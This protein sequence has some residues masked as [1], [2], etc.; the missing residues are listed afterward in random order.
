MP[1]AT[2][3]DDRLERLR[4]ILHECGSACV[5]YSGGVDS[6]FLASFAVETL[7]PERVLA[8]T[9]L[10]P[11]YPAV[12]REVARECAARFGIPHLEVETAE[13]DDPNYAANPANRC[14]Y[15][16]SE[17]WPRLAAVA[18]ERGYAAVLDGSN[19]DDAGD[20]RP[21]FVAARE[22]GVR[23]PLLEAGLTKDDIR[24]LSRERG[25][26][27]WDQPAAPCLSSR[28]PYG[29][30]VTPARLRQVELAEAALRDLGYR[31]F[32][33]RHHDDCLRL[34]F[35]PAE[36]EQAARSAAAIAAALHALRTPAPLLDVEGYRRGALNEVLV[37]LGAAASQAATPHGA[38]PQAATPHGATPQAATSHG[39]TPQAATPHAGGDPAASSDQPLP[40]HRAAGFHR[41][42][43]VPSGQ[44]PGQDAAQLL[45]VARGLVPRLRAAGFRYVA[46]DLQDL[47]GRPR[48]GE[49]GAGG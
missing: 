35:A 8:V 21:G 15:C 23:S 18:V 13:L 37:Q 5:G 29:V 3:L 6:V 22:N 1:A 38:T 12:Q 19:A 17:L 44:R 20:Y 46:L 36:L 31:E 26:P 4:Q 2:T 48:P 24:A 34:E 30:A 47:A 14:Y 32:R 9:G 10:S 25:L 7:G 16:K 27:T 33:V 40:P 49:R 41:D 43:A 39:A 42:I 28:L 11:A 45:A